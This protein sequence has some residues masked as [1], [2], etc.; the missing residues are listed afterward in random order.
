MTNKKKK[1]MSKHIKMGEKTKK[2]LL[3]ETIKNYKNMSREKLLGTL[4]E[5]EGNF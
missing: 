2:K 3:K 4:D 1:V 5:S